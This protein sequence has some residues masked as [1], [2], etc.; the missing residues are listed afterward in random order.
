M[1]DHRPETSSKDAA[2][3]AREARNGNPWQS[4]QQHSKDAAKDKAAQEVRE[5]Q[6]LAAQ[7][8]DALRGTREA[9]DAR[10]QKPQEAREARDARDTR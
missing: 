10:S 8:R 2:R 4:G 7:D 6:G 5:G 9:R 1:S 3:E